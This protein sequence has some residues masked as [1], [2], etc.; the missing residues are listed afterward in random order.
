MAGREQA[1]LLMEK[2]NES[3]LGTL[4]HQVSDM[5]AISMEIEQEVAEQNQQLGALDD[6][7]DQAAG[8]MGGA[9][10]RLNNITESA[11]GKH[12]L[13]ALIGLVVA[14]FVICYWVAEHRG[15][16]GT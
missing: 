14:M 2:Q 16:D 12:G 11:G 9:M 7:M 1:V 3:E 13:G 10:K 5:R 4:Q 6:Q 8:L 15:T